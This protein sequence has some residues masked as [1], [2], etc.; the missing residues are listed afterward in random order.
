MAQTAHDGTTA[1]TDGTSDAD[2]SDSNEQASLGTAIWRNGD[3]DQPVIIT[4]DLGTDTDGRRY[5]AVQ[6]SKAGIPLDEIQYEDEDAAFA[7]VADFFETV[8]SE[9][10]ES[11][12]TEFVMDEQGNQYDF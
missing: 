1:Q 2:E 12:I 6:E 8:S 7:E 4:A 10:P 3:V 11:V 9:T 5:V